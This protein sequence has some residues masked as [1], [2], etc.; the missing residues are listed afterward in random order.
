MHKDFK[1][2]HQG[3]L[4]VMKLRERSIFHR[5]ET[6]DCGALHSKVKEGGTKRKTRLTFRKTLFRDGAQ[7]S[8]NDNQ[9]KR[10]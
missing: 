2:K 3:E 4:Y 6:T 10:R 1:K 9:I 5:N 8:G 7:R